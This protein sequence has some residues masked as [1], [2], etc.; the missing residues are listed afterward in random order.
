MQV[1]LEPICALAGPT[2]TACVAVGAAFVVGTAN[3]Q[4]LHLVGP[5]TN[6]SA[7]ARLPGAHGAVEQ[8]LVLL[9]GS[10]L[11]MLARCTHALCCV[12]VPSLAVCWSLPIASGAAALVSARPPL[13][14]G[15]HGADGLAHF[16]VADGTRVRL[17]E[18]SEA[19][20]HASEP[21]PPAHAF[22]LV[23]PAAALLWARRFLVIGM[24]GEYL[25]V[26]QDS[27]ACSS[28]AAYGA[29][30]K[31]VVASGL[32]GDVLLLVGTGAAPAAACVRLEL[33]GGT[34]SAAG[35]EVGQA[36]GQE[37]GAGASSA[38]LQFYAHQLLPAGCA[39]AL[40]L[41]FP[42][43]F[44]L[45]PETLPSGYRSPDGSARL[46]VE[47]RHLLEPADLLVGHV[48]PEQPPQEQQQPQLQEQ[49]QA[50]QQLEEWTGLN[51]P[52][53]T[54]AEAE[55]VSA[56]FE[57]WS[58]ETGEAVQSE[59]ETEGEAEAAAAAG[60]AARPLCADS[61]DGGAAQQT[62][63]WPAASAL[64]QAVGGGRA[65]RRSQ[66]PRQFAAPSV[67][68]GAEPGQLL[69]LV[70]GRAFLCAREPRAGAPVNARV[71][72]SEELRRW[73]AHRTHP[74]GL[75]VLRGADELEEAWRKWLHAGLADRRASEAI[76]RT[77]GLLT[78]AV[79]DA[80]RGFVQ[81]GGWDH[82]CVCEVEAAVG[83][84]TSG[85]AQDVYR[86]CHAEADQAYS[87]QLHALRH[88]SPA[89]LGVPPAL[90]RHSTDASRAGRETYR[91]AV[92]L[93]RGLPSCV[94][95]RAQLNAIAEACEETCAL[96]A[97]LA[98]SPVGA[99][100][101]VPTFAVVL[102]HARLSHLPSTLLLLADALA[103]EALWKSRKG[104]ALVSAHAALSLLA[105]A[106]R[107][108]AAAAATAALG[109]AALA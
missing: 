38:D 92:A 10:V 54:A 8:L 89:E 28:L 1:R 24:S 4:L 37:G 106:A 41:S 9:D 95:Y 71:E 49:Q 13:R 76:G 58:Q 25:L 74:L 104:Y 93:L 16:C 51:G 42:Y 80:A 81:P 44:T 94:S 79:L 70:R 82:A 97:G 105:D 98:G 59:A 19:A 33:C 90:L 43:V 60:S 108:A 62:R 107:D 101:L 99:D 31:P 32:G 36:E 55:D 17:Y 96:A 109:S 29:G 20:A 6:P 61:G 86:T 48:P 11:V 7:R 34:A 27:G 26:E 23:E 45:A 83:A 40:C 35:G 30:L 3:G 102:L 84:A 77:A 66:P 52:E 5:A 87:A 91:T 12:A 85:L 88:A 14:S 75:L 21:P 53:E 100:E 39:A 50:Q 78:D 2:V 103:D 22:D 72:G 56:A 47:A 69:L 68:R 64:W 15:G 73:L 67:C 46:R 18:L 57:A 63:T 65:R